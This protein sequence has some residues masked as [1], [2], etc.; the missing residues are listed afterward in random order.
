[1]VTWYP[2][3][4]QM[5]SRW[6][7]DGIQM[8][9]RTSSDGTSNFGLVFARPKCRWDLTNCFTASLLQLE[10]IHRRQPSQNCH[11]HPSTM[12]D[13]DNLQLLTCCGS[14]Q[15][16]IHQIGP[17]DTWGLISIGT[18]L[19]GSMGLRLVSGWYWITTRSIMRGVWSIGCWM[20]LI[21]W[22]CL[23]KD[24]VVQLVH[25]LWFRRA[26]RENYGS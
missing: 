7:P 4:I 19:T 1:M 8:V 15:R 5:V 20:C 14:G 16:E 18:N 23:G 17:E 21:S 2:D 9:Q 11:Q 12:Y 22:A 25:R 13:T 26:S 10:S 3:G 6:Y 24:F